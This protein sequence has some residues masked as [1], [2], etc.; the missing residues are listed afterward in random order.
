MFLSRDDYVIEPLQI[1]IR[2]KNGTIVRTIT[3]PV[4]DVSIGSGEGRKYVE[5]LGLAHEKK[6][7]GQDVL[8]LIKRRDV[9]QVSQGRECVCR[10]RLLRGGR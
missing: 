8:D 1:P 2:D 10:L 3:A 4:F 7:S 5:V 9:I 6:L